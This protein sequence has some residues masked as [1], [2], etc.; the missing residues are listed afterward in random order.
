MKEI[1]FAIAHPLALGDLEFARVIDP[2]PQDCRLLLARE[3][4]AP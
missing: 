4:V 2:A 1:G 3:V